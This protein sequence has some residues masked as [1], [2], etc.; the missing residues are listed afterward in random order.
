MRALAAGPAFLSPGL[1]DVT[2]VDIADEEVFAPL[3]QLIRAA[4]FGEAIAAANDTR[5]GLA[6]GLVSDDPAL[7][8]R[9][10]EA[11]A[12]GVVNWNRPTTG[13]SGAA[14]FGGVGLSGNHRPAGYYAADYVAWPAA[15]LVAAGPARD[16]EP[17]P[18]LADG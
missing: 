12:A 7:F 14:P 17:M 13:A 15:S 6:A 11:I 8:A 1:I 2:G 9:F 10:D 18:G 3:L 5:F 16:D 4:G